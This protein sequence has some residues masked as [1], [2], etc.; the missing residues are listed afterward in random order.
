MCVYVC[1]FVQVLMKMS[2]CLTL[3]RTSVYKV[4][5]KSIETEAVFTKIEL[6]NE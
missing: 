6:N 2:V 3:N 1:V 5:S 4:F